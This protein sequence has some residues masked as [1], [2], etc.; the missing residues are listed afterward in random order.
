MIKKFGVLVSLISLAGCA[1]SITI[2]THSNIPIVV[3]GLPEE[4]LNYNL[5]AMKIS[6]P[7]EFIDFSK[8]DVSGGKW[9]KIK[10]VANIVKSIR[11]KYISGQYSISKHDVLTALAE[12]LTVYGRNM[13]I[14]G[15][16]PSASA[17]QR[18][19]L[20][21]S[22]LDAKYAT[23]IQ[24][25]LNEFQSRIANPSDPDPVLS[26]WSNLVKLLQQLE[27]IVPN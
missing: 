7:T 26:Y 13:M 9:D 23:A 11:S 19:P 3:S 6:D 10:E 22:N 24:P 20:S 17:M 16:T 5:I 25:Y 4:A 8:S 1:S 21:V 2:P 14:S 15:K 27:Q 18:H 12:Y